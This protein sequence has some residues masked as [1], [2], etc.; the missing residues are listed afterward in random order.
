MH[1]SI[2]LKQIYILSF[3]PVTK[4]TDDGEGKVCYIV[5]TSNNLSQHFSKG[6]EKGFR[7]CSCIELVWANDLGGMI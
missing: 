3:V 7:E 5:V 4:F 6:I 1:G 2:Y